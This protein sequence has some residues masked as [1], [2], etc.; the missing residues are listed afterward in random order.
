[1]LNKEENLRDSRRNIYIIAQRKKQIIIT[2]LLL[3]IAFVIY[4]FEVHVLFNMYS[5]LE[6]KTVFESVILIV[7]I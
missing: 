4:L 6:K 2:L 7:M 1:M 3:N 5:A